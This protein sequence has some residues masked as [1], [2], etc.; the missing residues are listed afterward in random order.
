MTSARAEVP[1]NATIRLVTRVALG[2]ALLGLALQVVFTVVIAPAV[3]DILQFAIPGRGPTLAVS[4]DTGVLSVVGLIVTVVA[5][6]VA[7]IAIALVRTKARV[8]YAI[9]AVISIVIPGFA[10]LNIAN[11]IADVTSDGDMSAGT[12]LVVAIL[13]IAAIFAGAISLDQVPKLARR[14]AGRA[15]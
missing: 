2:W 9:A 10:V 1:D 11:G 4:V 8:A 15:S 5:A 7:A 14:R 13:G 12:S 3:G 6:I